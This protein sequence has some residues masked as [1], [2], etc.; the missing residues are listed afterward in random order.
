[1]QR[2]GAVLALVGCAYDPVHVQATTI[3]EAV[4]E[5]RAKGSA[6]ISVPEGPAPDVIYGVDEVTIHLDDPVNIAGADLTIRSLLADC[7]AEIHGDDAQRAKYPRCRLFGS[8]L[9]EVGVHRRVETG[10]VVVG[11]VGVAVAGFIYCAGECSRP[12][13]TISGGTLAIAAGTAAIAGA[14]VLAWKLRSKH[15]G[16][17]TGR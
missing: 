12:Y 1:M 15:P 10:N 8:A 7:P 5:L 3:A 9:A 2:V 14:V 17:R 13:S 4:P 11:L 16:I 6:E